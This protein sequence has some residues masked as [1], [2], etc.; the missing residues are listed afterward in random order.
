MAR[1]NLINQAAQQG[2]DPFLDKMFEDPYFFPAP[3]DR[4][5]R[6]SARQFMA[7]QFDKGDGFDP[8]LPI[9]LVPPVI[10]QL[11]EIDAPM[12]LLA[13]ELDHPE[14]L[15]RNEYFAAQIRSAEEKIIPDA[16]HNGPMENPGAFLD[17][18]SSFLRAIA[19]Q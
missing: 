19:R 11:T 13:G 14:V 1:L 16:G 12:L 10:D 3:L 5:V 4:S 17:A 7:E 9:T 2:R 8:T 6:I 15:R 18:M